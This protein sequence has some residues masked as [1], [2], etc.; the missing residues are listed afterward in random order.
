MSWLTTIL[1]ELASYDAEIWSKPAAAMPA[2]TSSA[3]VPPIVTVF[4]LRKFEVLFVWVAPF[5][6]VS[7]IC[8]VPVA[9]IAE[10]FVVIL[11]ETIFVFDPI[12][13]ALLK[14]T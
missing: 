1:L 6:I 9:V 7:A 8:T 2:T 13:T 11:L 3:S 12:P 4:S 10:D 5:T 14:V